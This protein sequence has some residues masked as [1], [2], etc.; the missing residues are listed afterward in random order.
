MLRQLTVAFRVAL[1]HINSMNKTPNLDQ[2]SEEQLRALAAQLLVD[3]QQKDKTILTVTTE[4]QKL[5]HEMAILKRHKSVR[6]SEALN[7]QQ[8]SLLDDLVNED[9]AAIEE[10]L[11][12]RDQQLAEANHTAV[13]KRQPK[14]T[15]LPAELP[16][17]IILKIGGHY[18]WGY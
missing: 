5:K 14:R 12:L 16:R 10:Q 1:R 2:L 3:V 7:R 18:L 9:I 4:N 15:T 17:T 11:A 13:E 8:R 6:T